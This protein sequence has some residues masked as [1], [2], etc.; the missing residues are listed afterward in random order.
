[1]EENY[2]E[3]I[4]KLK[5][6]LKPQRFIHVLGVKDMCFS[7]ALRYGYDPKKAELAG[8]LHDLAKSVPVSDYIK[9][10]EE[11]SIDLTE[12]EIKNPQLIHAKLGSYLAKR[13]FNITDEEILNAICYHTTGK[14]SMNLLEKILYVSDYIEPSRHGIKRLSEIRKIAFEDLD[15]TVMETSLSTLEYLKSINADIDKKTIDTYEY[16]KELIDGRN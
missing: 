4:E 16:Y 11:Y 8:L 1:M 3:I 6:I 15:K 13:D 12:D 7:L 9:L 10:A 2:S 14:P 5:T